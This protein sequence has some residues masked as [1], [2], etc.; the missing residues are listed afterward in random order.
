MKRISLCV[1]FSIPVLRLAICALF[2]ATA[3]QRV[4]ARES[5]SPNP[6]GAIFATSSATG[7]RLVIQRSPVLGDN[8]AITLMIDGQVA[9]TLVRGRTYDRYITPGRHTLTALPNRSRGTWQGTL[10]VRPGKTYSYSA[11]Y[12]VNKLV[13]TPIGPR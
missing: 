12:N 4:D 11:S 7:G 5:N 6:T 2:I 9:G 13:L 8:V 1:P 10:D 3:S